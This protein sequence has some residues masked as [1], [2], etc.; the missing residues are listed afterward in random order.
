[1]ALLGY[2]DEIVPPFVTS[3]EGGGK[4]LFSF[5]HYSVDKGGPNDTVRR[6]NMRKIFETTFTTEPGADNASYVAEY[7]EPCT[8]YRFEKMLRFLD[9]NLRRHGS[10][11]SPGWLDCLDKWGSDV[12]W[13]IETFGSQFGYELK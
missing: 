10:K 7:G 8:I 4:G 2:M 3:H 13:L 12:D 9:T 5:M 6:H 11:T 1:M